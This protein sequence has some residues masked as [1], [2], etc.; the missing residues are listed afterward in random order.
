MNNSPT[1]SPDCGGYRGK[2]QAQQ[3]KQFER[4]DH[5]CLL[6]HKWELVH[7][8]FTRY[9]RCRKCPARMIYQPENGGYQPVNFKWLTGE[10][11]D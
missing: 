1:S 10:D 2:S 7:D 8:G 5:S 9:Y 4:I 6:W 11:D 3:M